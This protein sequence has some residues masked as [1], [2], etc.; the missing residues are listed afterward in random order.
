MNKEID[1]IGL[2]CPEPLM[3]VRRELRKLNNMEALIV[4]ADDSS[5]ERDFTLLCK[6]LNYSLTIL[7][8]DNKNIYKFKILKTA[9]VS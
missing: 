1:T 2:R 9:G 7:P 3:I 4:T 6:H 8:S 5:T